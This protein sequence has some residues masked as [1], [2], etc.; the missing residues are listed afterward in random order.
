VLAGRPPAAWGPRLSRPALLGLA[1]AALLA[2]AVWWGAGSL[3]RSRPLFEFRPGQLRTPTDFLLDLASTDYLR[4][5]PRIGWG[6]GL[7]LITLPPESADDT[8]PRSHRP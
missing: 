4:T 2:L 5:I 8:A 1:A 7:D 3:G 6:R